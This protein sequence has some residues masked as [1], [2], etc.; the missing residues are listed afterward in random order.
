M[1]TIEVRAAEAVV[2][3]PKCL[4]GV[5]DA[6]DSLNETL[7]VLYAQN[8]KDAQLEEATKHAEGPIA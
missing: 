8:R 3:I 2:L 6:I 7:K 1:T 4:K 5:I